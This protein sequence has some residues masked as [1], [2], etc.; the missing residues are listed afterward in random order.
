MKPSTLIAL[1]N[2]LGKMADPLKKNLSPGC[3]IVDETITLRVSGNIDK[4]DIVEYTPTCS[5]PLLATLAIFIEKSGVVGDS[6][7]NMLLDS[8]Q[9]A[10][11][12]GK[13]REDADGNELPDIT[14]TELIEERMKD[15]E[16][17]MERVK[18]L[19]AD[20]PKE[21]KSG[22]TRVKIEFEEATFKPAEAA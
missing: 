19:T 8:M 7:A 3:H 17:A 4:G 11:I 5:I 10:L 9:E 21:E 16:K 12:F 1:A 15:I 20:L 6:I 14:A 2:K 18:K 22:P 13:K